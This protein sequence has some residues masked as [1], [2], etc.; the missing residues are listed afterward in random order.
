MHD[1]HVN[2]VLQALVANTPNIQG[3]AVI[4]GDGQLVASHLPLTF[5]ESRLSATVTAMLPRGL[6]AAAALKCGKMEQLLLTG[7]IGHVLLREAGPQT[8]LCTLAGPGVHLETFLQA[9][10]RAASRISRMLSAPPPPSSPDTLRSPAALY[11][12]SGFSEADQT[13]VTQIWPYIRTALPGI[14]ERFYQ[15][16]QAEPQMAALIAGRAEMLKRVYL[17]WLESLFSGDYGPD[18]IRRQEEI[19]KA[20]NRAGVTPVFFAAGM[21]FLR[22]VFPPALRGCMPDGESAKAATAAV[23]RLLSFCQQIIDCTHTQ[24]LLRLEKNMA[25]AK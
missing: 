9:T 12:A 8:T 20:H 10:D 14:T 7:E 23:L 25:K 17:T 2:G 18:F 1:A 22:N 19:S 4:H 11:E 5:D 21:A 6:D 24:T 3:A 13:L 15:T 16:L